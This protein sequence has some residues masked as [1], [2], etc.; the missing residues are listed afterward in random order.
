VNNERTKPL[1]RVLIV[2]DSA[3]MRTALSR[4]VGCATDLEVAGTAVSGTEALQ[5]IASLDP[6]VVTLDMQMPGLDGLETLRRIMAQFPRPVIMVSSVTVKDAE[7]TFLALE[8]GA[9]DYVPKQLSS[10]SLNIVHI[11]E[12]LNRKIRT[13]AESRIPKNPASLPRKPP[14]GVE[15]PPTKGNAG[16]IPVIVAIGISTGGPKALQEMLPALPMD[17]SV[18]IVVVQHMPPGFTG[19]FAKRLNTLCAATVRE[20]THQEQLHAGVIYIAPAGTQLTVERSTQSRNTICLSDKPDDQLH[21]PSVDVMMQS[22]A[23]SFGSHVMGIIMTGMGS[24]GAQGMNA[25]RSCGG[26]T[27]GQDEATCAVYGMPRVCAEMGILDR[28]VPLSQIPYEIIQ[29]T[30]YR[31]TSVG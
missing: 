1:I 31:K 22:A 19:P 6:D 8:A 15:L 13:A 17:I 28:V 7:A 23:D 9:F 14:R 5:K 3:F 10:T 29:A 11:Q 24:D 4:M 27:L 25:I 2:D 12:D 21:V 30:R 18:P 26:F 16:P 20:A